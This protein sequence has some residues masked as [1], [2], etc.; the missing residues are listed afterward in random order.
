MQSYFIY[1][2]LHHLLATLLTVNV[3]SI[4]P[5]LYQVPCAL[6][7]QENYRITEPRT[8]IHRII[9]SKMISTKTDLVYNNAFSLCL[10]IIL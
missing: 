6:V 1:A 7:V 8:R 4:I 2:H 9:E 3:V 10:T 5:I